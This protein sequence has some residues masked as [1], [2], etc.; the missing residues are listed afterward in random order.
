MA[1]TTTP[2]PFTRLP[3]NDPILNDLYDKVT[4]ALSQSQASPAAAS[5]TAPSSTTPTAGTSLTDVPSLTTLPS[6]NPNNSS[7]ARDGVLISI[8]PSPGTPGTLYRY[9]SKSLKWVQA[10]NG[11]GGSGTLEY[12][13]IT[14]GVP[15]TAT[16]SAGANTVITLPSHTFDGA[17]SIYVE[18]FSP[19]VDIGAS[20]ALNI[21]LFQDGTSLGFMYRTNVSSFIGC[22]VRRKLTPA[23]GAHVY[24]IRAWRAV[25]NC[26]IQAGAG[27]GPGTA[28][29]AYAALIAY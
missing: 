16:T 7:Y 19:E 22:F 8:S 20:A 17:T 29:P 11:T 28:M 12:A 1:N 3:T 15:V 14:T 6:A 5:S 23:A 24:S 9:D 26:T 27:S 25:A 21:E 13:E 10:G 4:V 18:F 2:Q